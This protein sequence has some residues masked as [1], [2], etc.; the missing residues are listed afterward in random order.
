TI[1]AAPCAASWCAR[2]RPSLA[3]TQQL[4]EP[5]ERR[6]IAGKLHRHAE[7][8]EAVAENVLLR[9]LPPLD[10]RQAVMERHPTV[11]FA[12]YRDDARRRQRRHIRRIERARYRRHRLARPASLPER[13][14]D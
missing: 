5:L 4:P 1:S 13:A 9:Q 2:S 8:A 12:Q 3:R 11:G 7:M 6:W 14:G 10:Q